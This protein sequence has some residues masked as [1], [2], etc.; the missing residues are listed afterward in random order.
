L[1]GVEDINCRE[2]TALQSVKI[3]SSVTFIRQ[4]A[5]DRC[6]SLTSVEMY[7]SIEEIGEGA[8]DDCPLLSKVTVKSAS[9][10][11]FER[12]K[13]LLI[14]GEVREDVICMEEM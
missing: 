2:C 3:P 10:Q 9:Y 13:R 8:F 12:V 7:D 14:E 4:S 11:S 6:T 5:F 1:E